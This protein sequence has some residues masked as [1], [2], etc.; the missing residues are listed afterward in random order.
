MTLGAG[1]GQIQLTAAKTV[2]LTLDAGA[3]GG[4]GSI[5]INSQIDDIE[6]GGALSVNLSAP[7]GGI[8]IN[9]GINVAG[10]L[11]ATAVTTTLNTDVSAGNGQTY[12][13]A[14]TLG[15]SVTL[16]TSGA[17]ITLNGQVTGSGN[18][19]TLTTLGGP[20]TLHGVTTTGS[21]TL[22]MNTS[23]AGAVLPG[24]ITLDTGTY[25]IGNDGALYNF[26][27]VTTNGVLTIGLSTGFGAVTL[28]SDTTF[29]GSAANASVTFN[30]TIDGAH[31]L[32]VNAGAGVA[33]FDGTVGGGTPLTSLSVTSDPVLNANVTT[34][35]GGQTYTGPT[36]LGASI[37]L[38]DTDG[39]AIALNGQVT[40]GAN[41]LT[42]S[43]AGAETLSGITTT[44]DLTLGT[45][46]SLTLDGG[47]YQITGSAPPYVFPAAPTTLNGTLALEQAT[48]FDGAVT[49]G[50]ATTVNVNGALD[51][52][53]TLDGG[54]DL[55][56]NSFN[57]VTFGVVG[58][59]TPLADLN[60]AVDFDHAR[61]P[62]NNDRLYRVGHTGFNLDDQSAVDRRN[63]RVSTGQ[64]HKPCGKCHWWHRDRRYHRAHRV[65]RCDNANRWDHY[66]RYADWLCRHA[67]R[68]QYRSGQSARQQRDQQPGQLCRPDHRRRRSNSR[69]RTR[70]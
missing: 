13:S 36:S 41:S 10:N 44:G 24:I 4:A 46:S 16:F 47:T 9:N 64:Q 53:S 61:R 23:P 14:I 45:P 33:T 20:A 29:D 54:F 56:I 43:T 28:G 66:R 70:G 12:N 30:S 60:V 15:N 65:P 40:G 48:T 11:I 18:S 26:P 57:A 8:I 37:I 67:V 3:G 50:S 63:Q 21:G 17:A 55:T 19:L 6:L 51:F 34:A 31:A 7:N 52:A 68:P 58:G 27:A 1:D 59:T 2:S 62:N 25:S 39:G 42:L 38:A 69:L 5:T 32:V 22:T 49:L 35:G